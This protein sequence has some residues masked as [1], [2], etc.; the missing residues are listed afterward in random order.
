MTK[1]SRSFPPAR[2]RF[3]FAVTQAGW[4]FGLLCV[5]IL[6]YTVAGSPTPDNPGRVELM[7]A[8][9][10]MAAALPGVA[11]WLSLRGLAG[12]RNAEVWQISAAGLLFFGLSIPLVLGVLG[13]N[14]TGG[15]LRDLLPFLLFLLP[16]FF[17]DI[18]ARRPDYYPVLLGVAVL[19]GLGFA[20]R[21]LPQALAVFDTAPDPLSYLANAPTVLFAALLLT[22]KGLQGALAGPGWRA[23]LTGALC[24][25]LAALPFMAMAMALQRASFGYA[26]V[27]VAGTILVILYRQPR[28]AIIPLLIVGIFLLPFLHEGIAI[29]ADLIEKTKRTG[30]NMRVEELQA[31]WRA[32]CESPLTMLLGQGWGASFE[33]PAVGGVRVNYTH[34][35][36]SAMLL[37]TGVCGL[38][39]AVAYLCA[40]GR[41]LLRLAAG[42]AL[43]AA[44][45]AGPFLINIFFYASYKSLDFGLL[46]LLIT[47]G[48]AVFRAGNIASTG[49]LLYAKRT[50]RIV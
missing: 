34:S 24:L 9:L 28:R 50:A 8:L 11:G 18:F 30:L 26:A 20:L 47:A 36:L 15:I 31:V 1:Q 48:A 35:L 13:N 12:I 6:F 3:I 4:R 27:F 14:D 29:Y 41:A 7:L 25:G 45:L 17:T 21:S 16:L 10:L 32:I 19:A 46:L 40:L 23:R 49:R 33:S 22:G 5:A 42:R 44:A 37:K 39:L 43:L 38:I 2:R